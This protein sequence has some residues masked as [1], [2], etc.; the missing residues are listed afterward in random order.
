[1]TTPRIAALLLLASACATPHVKLEAP[2]H[3]APVEAR[4]AA[5]ERLGASHVDRPKWVTRPSY[6][7]G[8]QGSST[9]LQRPKLVLTDGRVLE[10]PEDI[11]PVVPPDSLSAYFVQRSIDD[12]AWARFG[13]HLAIGGFVGGIGVS[14]MGLAFDRDHSA[15]LGLIL[16]GTVVTAITTFGGIFYGLA[17]STDAKYRAA[18]AF[19]AYDRDLLERLD[20][21]KTEDGVAA[22]ASR[23][24]EGE[25]SGS[26]DSDE[27]AHDIGGAGR[28]PTEAR[29]SSSR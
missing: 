17:K 10:N 5:Y 13:L 29:T 23:P 6:S 21:C 19:H 16:T 12:K 18:D 22:C 27:D 9:S 1:M 7:A 3:D 20:L 25:P 14:A 8:R 24:E 11:L 26:G 4:V 28:R 15:R 2:A